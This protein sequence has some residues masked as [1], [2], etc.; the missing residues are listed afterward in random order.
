MDKVTKVNLF[1]DEGDFYST[2]AYSKTLKMKVRLVVFQP[3]EGTPI[4]YFSTDTNMSAKNVVEYYRTRF[5]IMF[6]FRDGKQYTGLCSV[7]T[8]LMFLRFAIFILAHF[9]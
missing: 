9:Q 8:L 2:I 1:P 3:K 5:Q 4:L 6:C 7:S